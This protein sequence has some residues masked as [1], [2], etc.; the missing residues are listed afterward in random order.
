MLDEGKVVILAVKIIIEFHDVHHERLLQAVLI[1][2]ILHIYKSI[3]GNLL[4][5]HHILKNLECLGT[6]ERFWH[7]DQLLFSDAL[8][9]VLHLILLLLG[10]IGSLFPS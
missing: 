10:E 3:Q 4:Q 7:G 8:A 2:H 9:L 5:L 6:A 1:V